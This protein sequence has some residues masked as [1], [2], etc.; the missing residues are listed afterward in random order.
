MRESSF[1]NMLEAYVFI[2]S[3]FSCANGAWVVGQLILVLVSL[4]LH[5]FTYEIIG[6]FYVRYHIEIVPSLNR[7][8]L[9]KLSHW[10]KIIILDTQA[11]TLVF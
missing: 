10:F 9:K 4:S 8:E 2:T 6:F 7:L 3:K 11:N 1:T 5:L